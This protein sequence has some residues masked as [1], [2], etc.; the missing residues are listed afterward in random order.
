[1]S[2]EEKQS[3]ELF[4]QKIKITSVLKRRVKYTAN[5]QYGFRKRLKEWEAVPIKSER[6][7]IVIGIRSL[8]NGAT[9]WDGEAGYMYSPLHYFKALLVVGNKREKPFY[10]QYPAS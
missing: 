1:M 8:S 5:D 10:I 9:D 7:V 4:G 2:A 6:E 3:T